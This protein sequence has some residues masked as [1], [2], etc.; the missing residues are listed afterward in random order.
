[1]DKISTEP[2]GEEKGEKL[3][4]NCSTP[5]KV[6]KSP[7]LDALIDKYN[8]AYPDNPLNRNELRLDPERLNKFIGWLEK[9]ELIE[10]IREIPV[11]SEI[12]QDT[13]NRIEYLLNHPAEFKLDEIETVLKSIGADLDKLRALYRKTPGGSEAEKLVA[14]AMTKV[15][16]DLIEKAGADLDELRALYGKTP[17]GSKA[18]ELVAEAMTKAKEGFK[19]Y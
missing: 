12:I 1:M 8:Q 13:K 4:I 5:K 2:K 10:N 9:N 3:E 11:V 15:I 6:F 7:Q 14:E 18:Q 17:R 19:N 16:P